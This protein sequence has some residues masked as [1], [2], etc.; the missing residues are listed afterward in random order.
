MCDAVPAVI[1]KSDDMM[2]ESGSGS[3][4][5]DDAPP[6][7]QTEDQNRFRKLAHS[8]QCKPVYSKSSIWNC[9]SEPHATV[10]VLTVPFSGPYVRSLEVLKPTKSHSIVV[11]GIAEQPFGV[12]I[13]AR[14]VGAEKET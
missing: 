7:P 5:C 13:K 3:G 10:G 4:G 1:G 2:W 14:T 6:D 9:R 12:F 11:E 8:K